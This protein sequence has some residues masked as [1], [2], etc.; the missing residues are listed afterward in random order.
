LLLQNTREALGR[1]HDQ[2]VESDP[3]AEQIDIAL[4]LALERTGE[5][6]E[7]IAIGRRT[8][9]LEIDQPRLN[10]RSPS[11][12][13]VEAFSGRVRGP[14]G[15][16]RILRGG[17]APA[18][19]AATGVIDVARALVSRIAATGTITAKQ[20]GEV[21]I[22]AITIGDSSAAIERAKDVGRTRAEIIG[23]PPS[24]EGA[25]L[26]K[27]D[28]QSWN[29]GRPAILVERVRGASDLRLALAVARFVGP[30]EALEAVA[31]LAVRSATLEANPRCTATGVTGWTAWQGI[32]VESV[33][34][35]VVLSS[36]NE[37]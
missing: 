3:V 36:N 8:G 31:A 30:R 33:E 16:E 11:G 4:T 21:G 22:V 23:A 10:L 18:A 19:S 13:V 12:I 14:V 15:R 29:K 20:A 25:A 9:F 7:R 1:R 24:R 17:R 28:A 37:V 5:I 27:V 2:V 6:V 35:W 34:H 32:L 26:L